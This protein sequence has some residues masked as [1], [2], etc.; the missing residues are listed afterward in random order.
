[1]SESKTFEASMTRLEQIV[2]QL[3]QGDAP[4]EDAMKLFEEGTSLISSCNELLSKAEQQVVKLSKGADG[5]PV[6]EAFEDEE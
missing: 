1:M 5:S 4:L 6:E 3:E 2:R